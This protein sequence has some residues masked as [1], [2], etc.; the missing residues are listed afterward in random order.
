MVTLIIRRVALEG[1]GRHLSPGGRRRHLETNGHGLP[2]WVP[3]LPRRPWAAKAWPLSGMPSPRCGMSG[4]R[5]VSVS[6]VP[7]EVTLADTIAGRGGQR[8]GAGGGGAW[9]GFLDSSASGS[10]P[11][12]SQL[13]H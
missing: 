13:E 1:R 8:E 2:T 3:G 9:T 6:G 4:C 11:S 7:H 5:T 12:V 10:A